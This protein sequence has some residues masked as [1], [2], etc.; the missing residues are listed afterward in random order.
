MTPVSLI[1]VASLILGVVVLLV[2]LIVSISGASLFLLE[3]LVEVLLRVA[4]VFSFD[5]VVP[6][7]TANEAK[8]VVDFLLHVA[9]VFSTVED[10]FSLMMTAVLPLVCQWYHRHYCFEPVCF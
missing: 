5:T 9:G 8:V 4:R 10:V 1:G 7:E 6:F 2:C 3:V